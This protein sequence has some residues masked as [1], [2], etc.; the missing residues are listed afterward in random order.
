MRKE[1]VELCLEVR[2]HKP[3]ANQR[4][5]VLKSSPMVLSS[6]DT[7]QMVT[8]MVSGEE[9]HR[10]EK[11][12]KVSSSWIRWRVSASSNGPTAAC[13]RANGRPV[14]RTEKESSTG[15][16]AKY[17]KA[18]SKITTAMVREYYTINV[19]KN[20]KDNGKAAKRAADAYTHGLMALG[21]L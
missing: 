19:A 13:T 6:K 9:S 4:A 7:S 11:S 17:M 2:S 21:T 15:Q 18:N 3:Q 20:L 8:P 1:E 10:E 5:E 16:T 12:I 14:K